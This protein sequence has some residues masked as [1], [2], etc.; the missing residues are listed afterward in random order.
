MPNKAPKSD[1]IITART[2]AKPRRPSLGM[3]VS[4]DDA[5]AISGSLI[6]GGRETRCNRKWLKKRFHHIVIRIEPGYL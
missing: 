2:T 1:I 4:E 6:R 3:L 5:L